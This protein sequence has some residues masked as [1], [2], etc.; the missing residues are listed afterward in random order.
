M[1]RH[2]MQEEGFERDVR[3]PACVQCMAE[4]PAT[5]LESLWILL[6]MEHWLSLRNMDFFLFM[7]LASMWCRKQKKTPWCQCLTGKPEWWWC[8]WFLSLLGFKINEIWTFPIDFFWIQNYFGKLLNEL[9]TLWD[10]SSPTLCKTRA[11]THQNVLTC[12][13]AS[14]HVNICCCLLSYQTSS[15]EASFFGPP[16]EWGR[17][18]SN[19]LLSSEP[20]VLV[21]QLRKRVYL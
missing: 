7:L 13:Q 9:T 17:S 2:R 1:W 12:L 4:A 15:S 10:K 6:S 8:N 19:P 21:L 14:C 16:W 11:R 18:R 5:A 20:H 3:K